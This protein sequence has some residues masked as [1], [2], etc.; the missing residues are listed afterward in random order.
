MHSPVALTLTLTLPLLAPFAR[1][2]DVNLAPAGVATATSTSGF[3]EV[4]GWANDGN[5]DGFFYNS[6]TFTTGNSPGQSWQVALA[7]ASVINEVVI[8]NRADCCAE[9]LANFRVEIKL[10]N[11]LLFTQD[12]LTSGGHVAA[13]QALRVKVPGAG[14]TGDRVQ[15]TSLGLNPTGNHY[16][17]FSEVEVIRHGTGRNVNYGVYGTATASSNGAQASRVIDG[18]LVGIVQNNTVFSTSNG[19]GQWLQVAIERHRIDAIRLWPS[20]YNNGQAHGCGNLRVA[21]LDNGVE[22]FGQNI[23]PNALLPITGP[24]VITP[25]TNTSGDAVRITSLGPVGAL[26]R[27]QLAEVEILQ[28]AGFIGEQWAYGAGC[29][30]SAGVPKLSCAVRPTPGATLQLRVDNVPATGLAL[31][32]T[33][34]SESNWSGLPLPLNLLPAGAPGCWALASLDAT[35]LGIATAGVATIPFALP[36]SGVLGIRLFQ[37]AAVVDPASNSLGLVLSNALE[38]FI[39][40]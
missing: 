26:E 11:T 32:V 33:G 9:R 31:L 21:I 25:P 13:G 8:W 16:L 4:A 3:G 28:F 12:F 18:D 6:S 5:R 17:A 30:G 38:Q 34:L 15:L 22:V 29:L 10:G 20:T 40:F 1:A 27:V 36:S 23:L 7:G 24:T 2:Q 35:N 19:P 14:V 37:Q 39:G